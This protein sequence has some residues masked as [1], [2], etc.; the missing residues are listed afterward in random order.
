[1][2]T[3]TDSDSSKLKEIFKQAIIEAIEEKKDVVH[4]LLMDAMEDL[5]MIHAIQEGEKTGSAS[6]NEV[7]DI[8]EGKA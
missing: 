4:D 3:I 1:M 5:A 8:L 2:L 6:R 7:F